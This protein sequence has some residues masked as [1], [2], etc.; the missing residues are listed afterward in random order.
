MGLLEEE[1]FQSTHPRRVR[2]GMISR[3]LGTIVFQ[4]THP[5]RVRPCTHN[6]VVHNHKF[7]STHPR[8][9]RR[10]ILLINGLHDGFNPRTHVG[11]D[12]LSATSKDCPKGFNPRT[13][14]GCDAAFSAASSCSSSFNPRTHVGCD[15]ATLLIFSSFNV[16]IHAPT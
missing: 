3:Q 5:R 10:L 12:N 1:K 8:R 7:Q 11:C 4:S 14:V 2:H 9:V 13:H 6:N 15:S 16:S